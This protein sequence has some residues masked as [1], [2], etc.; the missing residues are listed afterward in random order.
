MLHRTLTYVICVI[1]A[2]LSF[3]VSAAIVSTDWKVAGDNL[4]T[5]DT[6]N[7]LEWLDLTVTLNRSWNDVR[8]ELGS[9][10]EFAGWQMAG[11]SQLTQFFNAFGGSGS[12]DGTPYTNTGV[13]DLIAPYWGDTACEDTGCNVGDGWSKYLTGNIYGYGYVWQGFISDN[14]IKISSEYTSD[15]FADPR[16]GTALFRYVSPVPAP[17]AF[18]LML[19]GLSLLGLTIR[20]RKK[21]DEHV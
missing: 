8:S 2:T 3:N 21:T 5:R 4:I 17:P 12:Y 14:S 1:L 7:K 10:G 9:G 19:T 11:T 15:D 6:D 18:I 20:F 13:F 16:R